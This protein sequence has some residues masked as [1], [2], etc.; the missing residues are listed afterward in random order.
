MFRVSCFVIRN[1]IHINQTNPFEIIYMNTILDPSPT[2]RYGRSNREENDKEEEED[3]KEE[4]EEEDEKEEEEEEDEKEEEEEE[5]EKEE[6]DEEEDD[7]EEDDDEE[8][9]D[10]ETPREWERVREPKIP[11]NTGERKERGTS[12]ASRR[13]KESRSITYYPLDPN[14]TN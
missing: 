2:E 10:E 1:S 13:M 9:E 3:E 11:R 5:D 12:R 4:E 8:E 14:G 7:D 6:D